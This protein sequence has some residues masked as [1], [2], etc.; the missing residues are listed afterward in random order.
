[1]YAKYEI[2]WYSTTTVQ[3]TFIFKTENIRQTFNK[4]DKLALSN[5][6]FKNYQIFRN[7]ITRM[8]LKKCLL[9]YRKL[10]DR[11]HSVPNMFRF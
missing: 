2:T 11:L 4:N 8:D 5:N 3:L 10:T 7:K 1:M 9:L 6:N